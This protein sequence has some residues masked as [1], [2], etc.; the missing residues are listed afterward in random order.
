MSLGPLGKS[1]LPL[2]LAAGSIL[3][4]WATRQACAPPLDRW[5][6]LADAGLAAWQFYRALLPLWSPDRRVVLRLWGLEWTRDEACCHF[7]VTGAT[8]TGKTARAVVPI[9]HGLRRTLPATGILAIDSKGVLWRP[10]CEIARALG[11]ENDLR[12]IRVRPTEIPREEWQPPLR[13]NFLADRSV[14]WV[15]YAKMIVDTATASGQRGGQA[16]FKEAARDAITH[17]MQALDLAGL[18]VALDRVHDAICTSPGNSRLLEKLDKALQSDSP[19]AAE[20]KIER[21]YFSDFIAQPPEQKAGTVFTVA[22]FLRPYTPPDI[23]EVVGATEP[24]FSLAEID[25]GRVVCLSVP[26]TYQVERKYLNLLCKQLFFLHAFRRFDLDAAELHRRN[27]IGLVLDEG[28]KTT[29]V[30]EDGFAD[31]ATVDELREA[32]VFLIS[33][34]QTP[35]SFHA[36]F[37][38]ELKAD[39]FMANH[40]TQ[41]HFRA[42]DEKGAR[43]ISEKM[44]GREIRKY[45]GGVNGSQRARNWQLSDEPWFKP[46][47]LLALRDGCAVIRHPRQTGRPL[48]RRLPFT[49]FTDPNG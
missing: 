35:L 34:T 28:Q 14:P 36:S 13:L 4:A 1:K 23:A 27:L 19:R 37:A 39:V 48:L 18:P 11:Q 25:Q 6:P 21:Q 3:A 49:S 24:N 41:I 33:A 32:G 12:L 2:G 10:L 17:A 16:F 29:L 15:T 45:S 47:Q 31:H 8:G 43:I 44:G 38:T 20:A 5:L 40:R 9:L 30:S 7:F 42:A 46:A 26:Q 22:N